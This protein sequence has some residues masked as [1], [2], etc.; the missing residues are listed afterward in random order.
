[1]SLYMK[2]LEAGKFIWPTSGSGEAV[3]F[4]Y[5]LEGIDWRNPRWTQRPGKAGQNPAMT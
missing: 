2:R 4:G 3:Q 1:M 5:L